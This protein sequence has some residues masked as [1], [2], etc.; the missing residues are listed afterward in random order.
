M[1]RH[2]KLLRNDADMEPDSE[3]PSGN[4]SSLKNEERLTMLESHYVV[5]YPDRRRGD[6]DDSTVR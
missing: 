6:G 2:A 1:E 4:F 5:R 3:S